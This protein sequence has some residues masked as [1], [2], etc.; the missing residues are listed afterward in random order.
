[1]SEQ[2]QQP[3]PRR[4]KRLRLSKKEKWEAILKGTDKDEVPIQVLDSISVNL[5][6]G[7][8]VNIFVKQLLEE[9]NDPTELEQDI[10]RRLD[11]MDDLIKDVDFY[12]SVPQLSKTVQPIT[13]KILKNL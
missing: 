7:T 9:G 2:N 6:D 8:S 1:M 3:R 11:D 4:S 5:K 12:I 13:D 10:Q